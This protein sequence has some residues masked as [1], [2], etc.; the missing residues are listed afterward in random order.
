MNNQARV[1]RK[2]GKPFPNLYAGGGAACGVS[3]S[4]VSGYLT[5]NGLLTAVNLGRLAGQAATKQITV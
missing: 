1:L 5:G 2:D 4:Q 3:G